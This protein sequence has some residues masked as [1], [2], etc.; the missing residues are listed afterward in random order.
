MTVI[1]DSSVLQKIKVLEEVISFHEVDESAPFY[2]E[3]N[4][5]FTIS[6]SAF[7]P[8]SIGFNELYLNLPLALH[9]RMPS[10]VFI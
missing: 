1:S 7:H 10:S 3:M 5:P 8:D 9:S 4:T 6:L 2:Q